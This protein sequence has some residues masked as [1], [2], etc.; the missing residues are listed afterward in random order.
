[1]QAVVSAVKTA[2]IRQELVL[3]V[4]LVG[5]KH[6]LYPQGAGHTSD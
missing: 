2:R 6:D 4:L 3:S 5:P 1:M